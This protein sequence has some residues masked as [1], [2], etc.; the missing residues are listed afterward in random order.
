MHAFAGETGAVVAIIR[1]RQYLRQIEERIAALNQGKMVEIQK[2]ELTQD[3]FQTYNANVGKIGILPADQANDIAKLYI[4]AGQLFEDLTG[5][6][7]HC[8]GTAGAVEF[9][10]EMK[11][12]VEELLVLGDKILLHLRDA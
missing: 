6:S 11:A 5:E 9:L 2:R 12:V 8:A 7:P 3:Y 1:R 10:S 4:F